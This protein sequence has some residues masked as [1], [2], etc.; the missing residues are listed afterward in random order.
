VRREGQEQRVVHRVKKE[1]SV[2]KEFDVVVDWGRRYDHMQQVSRLAPVL[3][4]CDRL[5]CLC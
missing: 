5:Q 2:G 3:L 1:L 4:G